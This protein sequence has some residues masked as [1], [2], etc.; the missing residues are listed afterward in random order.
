MITRINVTA[1]DAFYYDFI[2]VS[3]TV[4]VVNLFIV[5]SKT[6]WSIIVLRCYGII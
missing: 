5:F 3:L 4:V 1:L 6:D 2:D